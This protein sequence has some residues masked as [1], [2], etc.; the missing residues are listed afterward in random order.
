MDSV[1]KSEED[2][3]LLNALLKI[4]NEI[5]DVEMCSENNNF[6]MELLLNNEERNQSDCVNLSPDLTQNEEK[7][8]EKILSEILDNVENVNESVFDEILL[9]MDKRELVNIVGLDAQELEKENEAMVDISHL[10]PNANIEQEGFG[11]E[12][13]LFK[14]VGEK[15]WFYKKFNMT[16]KCYSLEINNSTLK[17]ES[18]AETW[19][20]K[21]LNGVID[22]FKNS[23]KINVKPGDR[24]GMS[25]RNN[26]F[27]EN[28]I[29]IGL[30][31]FDQLGPDVVFD[32]IIKVFGSNKEFFLNGY[33]EVTFDHIQMPHGS[34]RIVRSFGETNA[35]FILKKA[36]FMKY[37]IPEGKRFKKYLNDGYCLPYALVIARAYDEFSLLPKSTRKHSYY[38]K[39][40][41]RF[42][43]L[44]EKAE[45]LCRLAGVVIPKEGCTF[46]EVKQFQAILPEYQLVVYG[47]DS[48]TPKYFDS[49][50]SGKR[51]LCLMLQEEH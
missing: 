20:R 35:D 40:Q 45:E 15:D 5:N 17:D 3:L 27:D 51:K 28:P 43:G 26:K 6:V 21:I 8:F 48:K 19:M 31:R 41:T 16:G 38:N 10:L 46:D 2:E 30:I 13:K 42:K 32:H 34:G 18:D 39:Y 47:A 9:D 36:S 50:Y 22:Y 29:Y 1:F 11:M 25:F 37:T 23:S 44:R 49:S 7:D 4:E 33:L 24:V 12:K 14:L